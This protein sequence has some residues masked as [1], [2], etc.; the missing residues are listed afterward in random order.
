MEIKHSM[1]RMQN[2]PAFSPQAV[3]AVNYQWS[4]TSLKV[5]PL[6]QPILSVQYKWL[7]S[8][9]IT[10]VLKNVG[11]PVIVLFIHIA[12]PTIPTTVFSWIYIVFEGCGPR[13]QGIS[14]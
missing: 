9:P 11:N 7:I 6:Y 1:A 10:T 3:S 4:L 8:G 12:I 13:L 5:R 14:G 2:A